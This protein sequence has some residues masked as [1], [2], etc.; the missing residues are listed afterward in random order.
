[1]ARI[2]LLLLVVVAAAG[3]GSS[4]DCGGSTSSS[5]GGG[6]GYGGGG[7]SAPASNAGQTVALSADPSGGLKFSSDTASAKPGKVTI[8]MTNPS[9][10]AHSIAVEGNGVDEDSPQASV[11]KGQKA[12][13]TADLKP[14][15]YT[16]Y[17][18]VDGHEQA[19]MKGTLTVK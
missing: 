11:G 3:C 14:G 6:G 15:T 9:S 8:Q 12:T 19:G 18:P 2:A 4:D 1:M 16:F 10:T 7:T 13:V 17:C 5:G